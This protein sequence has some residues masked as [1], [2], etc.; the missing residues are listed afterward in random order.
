M[1]RQSDTRDAILRFMTEFQQEHNYP[2]SIREIGLALGLRSPATIHRHIGILEEEGKLRREPHRQRAITILATPTPQNNPDTHQNTP[3]RNISQHHVPQ[4]QNI[5]LLGEVA[6]GT[7]TIAEQQE[8][9]AMV[10]PEELCGQGELFMLQIRGD[11]MEDA[12]ILPGDYVVVR[13]QDTARNGDIVVAGIHEEEATVKVYKESG[14]PAGSCITLVPKS[15]RH[16]PREFP[17]DEVKIY[18]KVV[19]V[20]R[21]L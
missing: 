10:I 20:L 17:S 8:L 21:R 13:S 15:N 5:P 1:P 6:A 4:H 14:S 16:S 3:Q 19:S 9:G 18:G 2:P 12:A 7:G 11:S